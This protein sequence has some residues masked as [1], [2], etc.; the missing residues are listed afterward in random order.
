MTNLQNN[1]ENRPCVLCKGSGKRNEQTCPSCEGAGWF[2]PPAV[3]EILSE[4]FGKRGL[5][6]KRPENLRSYY[7]WRLARFNSGKDMTLPLV[8][9][10]SVSGDPF[11]PELDRL[12]EEATRRVR[13]TS[14]LDPNGLRK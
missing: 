1:I 2:E 13:A 8:A 10:L 6:S 9:S 14:L 4:I 5:R 12:A 7:V 11:Q 3:S